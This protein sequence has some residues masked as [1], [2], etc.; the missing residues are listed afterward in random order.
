MADTP[1][2]GMLGF[3]HT[4]WN[5][6]D[7]HIAF[8]VVEPVVVGPEPWP[9]HSIEEVGERVRL[10]REQF[11]QMKI[12]IRLQYKGHQAFPSQ[13]NEAEREEF[14]D[15]CVE[16]AR[17]AHLKHHA[18]IWI[19]SNEPNIANEGSVTAEWAARVINGGTGGDNIVQ[20][21]RDW[22]RGGL[23]RPRKIFAPAPAPFDPTIGETDDAYRLSWDSHPWLNYT[24]SFFKRLRENGNVESRRIDGVCAHVASRIGADGTAN[25]GRME[26]RR[27][28]R[29]D[30]YGSQFGTQCIYE[31]MDIVNR[32]APEWPV[33]VDEFTSF[34]DG[35]GPRTNY[36]RGLLFNMVRTIDTAINATP[37]ASRKL[38]CEGL[39]WFIGRSGV[40]SPW[41]ETSLQSLVERPTPVGLDL[42]AE[43]NNLVDY[44]S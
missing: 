23:E 25:L 19:I 39:C 42:I 30:T 27:P 8:P 13:D 33:L 38:R 18:E 7:Q 22:Q 14:Q 10:L 41:D 6:P 16:A 28:V 24:Y 44:F 9:G 37:Y 17:N 2:L 31:F 36:P 3:Y 21:L 43:Y 11:P 1:L 34:M 15:L 35:V 40:G 29:E 26:P 4:G 12:H 20:S 5:M 32:I